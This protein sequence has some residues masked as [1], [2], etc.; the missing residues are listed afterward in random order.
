VNKIIFIVVTGLSI[1]GLALLIK[2]SNFWPDIPDSVEQKYQ[3]YMSTY[4]ESPAG[5]S[6]QVCT[7]KDDLFY[8]AIG[9]TGFKGEKSYFSSSGELIGKQP[10]SDMWDGGEP[11]PPKKIDDYKCRNIK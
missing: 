2:Q 4:G 9:T 10:I 1:L 5:A 6:L 11:A 8:L 3:E 7:S